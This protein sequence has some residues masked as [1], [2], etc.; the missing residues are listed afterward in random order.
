MATKPKKKNAQEP[1]F[2]KVCFGYQSEYDW[3]IVERKL[4]INRK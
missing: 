4:M 2:D 3:G 1:D